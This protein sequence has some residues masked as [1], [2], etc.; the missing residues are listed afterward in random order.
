[1]LR[2]WRLDP[3]FR[4][5]LYAIFAALFVSGA[6]WLAA[7]QLKDT[8]SG[9]LWQEIAQYLLMLHGGTAMLILLV[10]GAL[11]PLHVQ[12]AWR[13]KQ[14]RTTGALMLA[15]N[16]VLIATA[17]ALYYLG[18]EVI[19]PWASGFHIAVGLSLPILLLT[20]VVLGRSSN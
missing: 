13:A 18:S 15:G 6:A 5:L 16:G 3:F 20:H 12:R 1:M 11:F 8:S 14:N 9:D 10:L 17:F 2:L 19:R 7:D 4:F